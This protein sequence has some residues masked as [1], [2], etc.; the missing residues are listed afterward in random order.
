[1]TDNF[2]DVFSAQNVG[3]PFVTQDLASIKRLLDDINISG[4][5]VGKTLASGFGVAAASGRS[6][7]DVLASVAQSLARLALRD[8]AKALAESLV[9]SM[10]GIFSGAFSG[11]GAAVAPFAE[12]GVIASPTYFANGSSMGLMGE[13]GAEAVM[14][15]ARAPDGRLGVVSQGGGAAPLT[16]NVS[17]A[18]QDIESFRRSETQI[19][20]ALAR[21]VARGQR[22]L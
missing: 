17:I 8:G 4:A 15:L 18:A 7:N 22:S 11:G 13:R 1:M 16:I 20:G 9:S 21:A 12:G 6:F 3:A 14:P 19:T 5:N 2:P 10:S